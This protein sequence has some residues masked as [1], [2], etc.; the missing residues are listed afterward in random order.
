MEDR[1]YKTVTMECRISHWWG[2]WFLLMT[3]Y[4]LTWY[5][6]Y[7]FPFWWLY[8]MWSYTSCTYS[9]M[10]IRWFLKPDP[11][12]PLSHQNTILPHCLQNMNLGMSDAVHSPKVP[13]PK[14]PLCLSWLTSVFSHNMVA[15][16]PH[17][18]GGILSFLQNLVC[19]IALGKT[20]PNP[21]SKI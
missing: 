8:I 9:C 18:K 19:C 1:L 3:E 7:N 11:I 17:N 5:V 2:K 16:F 21:L 12:L 13:C 14:V 15:R 20:S 4:I 10:N 6:E